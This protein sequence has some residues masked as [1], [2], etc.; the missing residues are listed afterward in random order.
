MLKR[1]CS[2]VLTVIMIVLLAAAPTFA[3]TKITYWHQWTGQWTKVLED[4]AQMFNESQDEI[5]VTAVVVPENF[6]ERLMSSAAV[7]DMPD[8]VSLTGDGNLYM[9]ERGLFHAI[10]KLMGEDEWKRF[11]EWALPVVWEV[12]DWKGHVWALTPYID[13]HTLYYNKHF[14]SEA[15]LDPEAPPLTIDEL[16]AHAEKLTRYDARGNIDVIGFYPSAGVTYWGTV[17]GGDLVDDRGAPS[18]HKDPK[19][20]EAM[21]WIASYSHKYD[22]TKLVAFEAGISEERAGAL[23]P[24]ISGKIAMQQQG[25]WVII[26]LANYTGDDFSYGLA[27]HSPT[28]PGGRKGGTLVRS[29]YGALAVPKGSKNPEA[30]LEFIKFWIGYGYEAQRAKIFEWGAWMP[31][32]RAQKIWEEPTTVQ[33]LN[34]FPQFAAFRDV[35]NMQSWAVMQSPVD[36]FLFDRIG[37]AND[38]A[39]LLEKDPAKALEDAAADVMKEFDRINR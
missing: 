35:L 2:L 4:I 18:F 6:R 16:D 36:S 17:F 3:K 28:P 7:G 10:D 26:N 8:V 12:N 30:A 1:R 34:M 14:F 37:A 21:E 32:D 20:L 22:V 19:M 29:A 38:Y 5:E 11:Q 24:F 33:Y 9:A 39:R 27:P 23:D 31:L 15:G 25:Q 13:C